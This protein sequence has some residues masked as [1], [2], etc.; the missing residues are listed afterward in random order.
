M[1]VK[2]LDLLYVKTDDYN[3]MYFAKYNKV[4]FIKQKLET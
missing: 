3:E 4:L 2:I 1:S